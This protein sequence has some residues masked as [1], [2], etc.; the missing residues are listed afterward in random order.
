MHGHCVGSDTVNHKVTAEW[1]TDSNCI[2]V[3]F[4]IVNRIPY[5]VMNEALVMQLATRAATDI[6]LACLA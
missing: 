3:V 6:A 4:L 1:G 5:M 2:V